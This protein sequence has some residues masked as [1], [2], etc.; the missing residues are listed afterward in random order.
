MSINRKCK[1]YSVLWIPQ[2]QVGH[3]IEAKGVSFTLFTLVE[4]IR[5][6]PFIKP[7]S[8]SRTSTCRAWSFDAVVQRRSCKLR[9]SI[10]MLEDLCLWKVTAIKVLRL[11]RASAL[12]SS[13][14]CTPGLVKSFATRLSENGSH[15]LGIGK[16]VNLRLSSC[17]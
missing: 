10:S 3:S 4:T 16:E 13:L 12:L 17:Y 11:S 2:N 14:Q 9:T 5:A 15:P 6:G 8:G 1:Q 7:A